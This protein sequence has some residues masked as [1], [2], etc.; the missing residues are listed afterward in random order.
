M[1]PEIFG[2]IENSNRSTIDAADY[3]MGKYV[4]VPRLEFMRIILQQQLIEKYDERLIL[5]YVSP[6]VEDKEFELQVTQAHPSNFT[7]DEIRELANRRKIEGG[8][9]FM[10]PINTTYVTNLSDTAVEPAPNPTP[11]PPPNA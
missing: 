8:T 1:P 2:I 10:V 7:I 3:L 11:E 4:L 5:D 9:G 6:V